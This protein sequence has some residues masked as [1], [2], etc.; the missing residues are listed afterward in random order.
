MGANR[1]RRLERR[2]V[3]R[4]NRAEK[5]SGE[6]ERRNRAEKQSGETERSCDKTERSCQ[7]P[8]ALLDDPP[9][10]IQG[11]ATGLP[12][13]SRAGPVLIRS[14]VLR[15]CQTVVDIV[16]HPDTLINAVGRRGRWWSPVADSSVSTPEVRV[17]EFRRQRRSVRQSASPA[18]QE[19]SVDPTSSQLAS[20]QLPSSQSPSSQ[21]PSSQS[22]SSQLPSSQRG[23]AGSRPSR[24]VDAPS[25]PRE[26]PDVTGFL[27]VV[28]VTL[29]LFVVP[30]G[31]TI[32]QGPAIVASIL[33]R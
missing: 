13:D 30:V 5:Q 4:R 33:G 8:G 19:R 12:L 27:V 9:R 2:E 20:S 21:S 24:R 26:L 11:R 28:L 18:I 25:S 15:Q 31:A 29:G 22:P 1:R 10:A 14:G 6:T 32:M 23:T 17:F 16:A 7:C 3:E